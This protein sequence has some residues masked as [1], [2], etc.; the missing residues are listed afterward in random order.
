LATDLT[1]K[2]VD[3]LQMHQLQ[4]A[5][6]CF[7]KA[8]ELNAGHLKIALNLGSAYIQD[9]QYER[10]VQVMEEVSAKCPKDALLKTNLGVAYLGFASEHPDTNLE[11]KAKVFLEEAI[12]LD[13]RLPQPYYNLGTISYEQENLAQAA[14]VLQQGLKQ[15]PHDTEMK[16]LLQEIQAG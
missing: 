11:E 9:E 15:H 16:Q 8:W 2:G 7:Q 10:A 6:A 1:N 3:Y 12:R 14:Q 13:K 4:S 5:I